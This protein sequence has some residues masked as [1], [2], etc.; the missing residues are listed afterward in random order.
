MSKVSKLV[1]KACSDN[2]FSSFTGEFITS[3]N[4]ENLSIKSAVSYDMPNG[5]AGAHLLKYRGL[6]PKVLSFSLLFDNTG[7]MPGSNAIPVTEQ[8]KQL[9]DVAYSIH[10]K[11]NAPN[12]IRII[13]GQIDF[14]GRLKDLDI[15]HAMFQVDGT[16]V[17]S[18]AHLSVLEELAPLGTGKSGLGVDSDYAKGSGAHATSGR[19][20]SS[21][22]S[23][24][25]QEAFAPTP[26]GMNGAYSGAPPGAYDG[27]PD[28]VYHGSNGSGGPVYGSSNVA[29]GHPHTTPAGGRPATATNPGYASGD[30][31]DTSTLGST[32]ST[33]HQVS[34][35]KGGIA[36]NGPGGSGGGVGGGG[37][38]PAGN[39][40][41]SGAAAGSHSGTSRHVG[42]GTAPSD[43]GSPGSKP[44]GSGHPAGKGAAGAPKSSAATGIGS[45][46]SKDQGSSLKA[47]IAGGAAGGGV[48]QFQSAVAN[49]KDSLRK[50]PDLKAKMTDIKNKISFWRRLKNF[51]KKVSPKAYNAGK[52]IIKSI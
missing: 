35:S 26:N 31:S 22:Q 23:P 21:N 28:Q 43:A 42:T 25:S 51:A 24:P 16:L 39:A 20:M 44:T 6:C 13:W 47:A 38:G 34:P 15:V 11:N 10:K 37:H 5:M 46:A 27:A 41:Q 36:G 14:K 3:I 4:P 2:K 1:I 49:G 19:K 40:P 33:H 17:R 45:G 9:Q 50:L 29:A 7:I 52:K 30:A 8:V 48:S 18:E 12:Y 32:D